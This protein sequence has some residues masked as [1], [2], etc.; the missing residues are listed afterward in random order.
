MMKVKLERSNGHIFKSWESSR[1]Q[2]PC[3]QSEFSFVNFQGIDVM[4]EQ[5]KRAKARPTGVFYVVHPL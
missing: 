4:M 2:F 5:G 1:M 3:S